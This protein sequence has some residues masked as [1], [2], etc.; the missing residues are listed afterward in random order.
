MWRDLVALMIAL[1]ALVIGVLSLHAL[2]G[3][4]GV[5]TLISLALAGISV[6]LG[7]RPTKQV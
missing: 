2:A 7:Y 3:W 5:G 4:A 6:A 1:L